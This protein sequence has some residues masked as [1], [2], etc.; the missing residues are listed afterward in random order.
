MGKIYYVMG[1]SASGKDTIFQKILEECPKMRKL[2]L[3]TTR[4]MR[5]GETDGVEYYFVDED[6]L[7]EFEKQGKL[8]EKRTYD[9]VFGPWSYA[10]VDAGQINLSK[11]DYAAIGTLESYAQMIDYF[12]EENL[13]PIFLE[14]DAGIR[15]QRAIN[16]E[17][18]Q[19]EP[20]YKELCRR[21][22]ADEEDFSDDKLYAAGIKKRYINEDFEKCLADILNDI[23]SSKKK[24]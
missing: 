7:N 3:Y 5:K 20:K 13:Y 22:L 4:P 16:R 2:I 17:R 8:I 9:T 24:E 11:R 1:K 14:I 23:D 6:R 12:G 18:M 19:K 15:L 10:T 21:F